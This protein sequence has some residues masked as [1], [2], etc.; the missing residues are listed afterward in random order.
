MLI[1]LPRCVLLRIKYYLLFWS[2]VV[3]AFVLSLPLLRMLVRFVS[4]N[5][6][7]W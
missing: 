4:I 7:C 1:I 2:G 6:S 3:V 5:P